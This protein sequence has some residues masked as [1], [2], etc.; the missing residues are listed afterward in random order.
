MR[1]PKLKIILAHL[2]GPWI[3]E[4]AYMAM[5]HKNM[6]VDFAGW[7]PNMVA[8]MSLYTSLLKFRSLMRTSERILGVGT[9]YPL[10]KF[11]P[12]VDVIKSF[13]ELAEKRGLPKL[14][15]KE[16]AGI[17]GDNAA[18]LLKLK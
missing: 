13:P 9:D 17:L 10:C 2:G 4:A 12:V 6:Y 18:K 15:D 5:K 11:K 7:G 8:P 3:T 16:I 1:F 14:S